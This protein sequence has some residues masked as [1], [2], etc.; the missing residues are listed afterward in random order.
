VGS[1]PGLLKGCQELTAGARDS[2][3]QHPGIDGRLEKSGIL[4][5]P[6]D[7][8]SDCHRVLHSEIRLKVRVNLLDA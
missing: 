8:S 3:Q 5:S 1:S 7:S 4:H 2:T 6:H